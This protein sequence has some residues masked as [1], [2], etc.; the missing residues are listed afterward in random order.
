[1]QVHIE[2][3]V[4]QIAK[5]VQDSGAVVCAPGVWTQLILS[6][7]GKSRWIQCRISQNIANG[8]IQIGRGA[9]G[10][11]VQ[12]F[13]WAFDAG[14]NWDV[15]NLAFEIPRATRLTAN[16]TVQVTVEFHVYY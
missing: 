3:P 8:S 15:G 7:S 13:H 16:P 4:F 14:T 9:P 11:E 6:T 2:S 1:M 5:S 12:L 10:G